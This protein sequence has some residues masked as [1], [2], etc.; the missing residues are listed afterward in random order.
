MFK[1]ARVIS[2]ILDASHP[3]YKGE[4]DIGSIVYNHIDEPPTLVKESPTARPL[5]SNISHYPIPNEIVYLTSAPHPDY[6]NN[7]KLINYYLYPH[8]IHKDP[9]LNALPNALRES[10]FFTGEYFTENESI[11]PLKPHEGDIIFEGRFGQSL[12]LGATTPNNVLSANQWSME[13]NVGSPITILRNGQKPLSPHVENFT[14]IVEDIN[15][16]DSSIYLCSGQRF[17]EF[18]PASTHDASY[19]AESTAEN[20]D[21]QNPLSQPDIPNT[22]IPTGTTKEDI[23]LNNASPLPPKEFQINDELGNFK[24]PDISYYDISPTEKQIIKTTDNSHEL[25]PHYQFS[26]QVNETFLLAD[27]AANESSV[28]SNNTFNRGHNIIS[29]VAELNNINNYPGVDQGGDPNLTENKI[30]SNLSLVHAQCINP[31]LEAF[32]YQYIRITSAY[33][34]SELNRII[35]GNPRS[36]H[37]LGNAVDIIS[38]NHSTSLIWNWCFQN[39]PSWHQLIW[40]YPERGEYTALDQDFS[41]I[42][43]SFIEGNNSKLTSMSSKKDSLHEA[44]KGELTTRIGNYTHGITLADENLL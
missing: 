18:K 42:H 28:P 3:H 31:I 5:N 16:D 10:S 7:N 21:E 39:L 8:S 32:G 20:T 13:G 24:S 4:S 1:L 26:N 30:W 23:T 43:I 6:N 34:S 17:N 11:R 25:P 40:E 38:T 9:N 2:I 14:H 19:M 35:K 37:I 15:R 41:W 33:R 36:Q 22:S 27:M 29:K 44:Y 12:R